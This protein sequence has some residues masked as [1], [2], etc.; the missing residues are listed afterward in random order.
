MLVIPQ[1]ALL[2]KEKGLFS[3]QTALSATRPA[4]MLNKQ[5]A[6]QQNQYP[7]LNMMGVLQFPKIQWNENILKCCKGSRVMSYM[8]VRLNSREAAELCT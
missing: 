2:M 3:T 6:G 5:A 1:D 4:K 7:S 8:P